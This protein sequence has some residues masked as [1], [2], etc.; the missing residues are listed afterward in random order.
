M[1]CE[2][3]T[4]KNETSTAINKKTI[5]N[6]YCG[7]EYNQIFIV[8]I[9]NQWANIVNWNTQKL[10]KYYQGGYFTNILF[11]KTPDIEPKAFKCL[12]VCLLEW[13]KH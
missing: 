13:S 10:N 2:I 12:K 9:V 6:L 7:I 8:N 4:P 1:L 11:F 3:L 5:Q